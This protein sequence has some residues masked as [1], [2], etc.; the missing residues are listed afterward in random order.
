MC[1]TPAEA[2]T[3]IPTPDAAQAEPVEER[4]IVTILFADLVGFTERSDRADP[5]DV[6]RTLRAF[7][8]RAKQEIERFGGSWTSSSATR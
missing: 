6:R 2:T 4:R 8:A 7:H 5:E 3:P 1:G